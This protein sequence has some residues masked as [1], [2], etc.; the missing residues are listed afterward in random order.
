M[1]GKKRSIIDTISNKLCSLCVT[2][3]D[4]MYTCKTP[5]DEQDVQLLTSLV[6]PVAHL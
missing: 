6:T 1:K 2:M 4:E 3:S 5:W